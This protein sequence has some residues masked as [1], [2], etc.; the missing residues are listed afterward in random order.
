MTR[1]QASNQAEQVN[2]KDLT[3]KAL[4]NRVFIINPSSAKLIFVCI[5]KF[6][7]CVCMC[8]CMCMYVCLHVCLY[9]CVSACMR[10]SLC[11]CMCVYLRVCVL[12]CVHVCLYV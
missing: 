7:V 4:K 11:F 6:R 2:I 10:I 3:R 1:I 9:V 5:G 12:I 8:A